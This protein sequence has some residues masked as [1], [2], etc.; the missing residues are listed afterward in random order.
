MAAFVWFF[1][2]MPVARLFYNDS[3]TTASVVS[4]SLIYGS[5][6]AVTLGA[7]AVGMGHYLRALE[8]TRRTVALATAAMALTGSIGVGICVV[9]GWLTNY[10]SAPAVIL[11]Y[12]LIVGALMA[13]GIA[14][15]WVAELRTSA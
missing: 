14:A 11:L 12:V 13:T 7:A 2:L 4:L 5:C 9:V 10:S 3:S 1:A 6:G 8:S 15:V